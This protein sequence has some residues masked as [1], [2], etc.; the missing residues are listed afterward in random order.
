ML[1]KRSIA[2]VHDQ[3]YWRCRFSEWSEET[4]LDVSPTTRESTR[5]TLLYTIFDEDIDTIESYESIL[6]YY[7]RRK[8]TFE[9]DTLSAVAGLLGHLEIRMATRFFYGLPR[10]AFDFAIL[11]LASSNESK[12]CV[13]H[14]R[15]GFPSYSWAGWRNWIYHPSSAEL[16]TC[17]DSAT[18]I[19]TW[20]AQR[21]WIIWYEVD[22]VGNANLIWNPEVEAMATDPE[23]H[24]R[25]P[26]KRP[27]TRLRRFMPF[28]LEFPTKPR[29]N[30]STCPRSYSLIGFC[31][32]AVFLVVRE[33]KHNTYTKEQIYDCSNEAVGVARMK[34]DLDFTRGCRIEFLLVS[35]TTLPDINQTSAWPRHWPGLTDEELRE[36]GGKGLASEWSFFWALAVMEVN[37]CME[38]I[39][40]ARI[41]QCVLRGSYAPGPVWKECFLA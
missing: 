34:C 33:I 28:A 36:R 21:T 11:F 6:L 9:S 2:F 32:M 13:S 17:K 39:G 24:I 40:I 26:V 15:P 25:Y 5:S 35:E 19:N 41:S 27:I 20:L 37:G 23:L 8:L 31:T 1:P 7:S 3:M 29:P 12:D 4:Y 18:D 16:G 10:S 22:I 14:R 38:R 30:W